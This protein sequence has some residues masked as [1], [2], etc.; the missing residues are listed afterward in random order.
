M[1]NYVY[2]CWLEIF[3]VTFWYHE[4]KEKPLRFQQLLN[5]IKKL[6]WIDVRNII[7]FN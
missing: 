5:M 4:E 2:L 7:L 6:K 1:E 3:A